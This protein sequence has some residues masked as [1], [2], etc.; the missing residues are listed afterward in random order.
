MSRPQPRTR[1]RNEPVAWNGQI[2]GY[3]SDVRND[4]FDLYGKWTPLVGSVT[5]DFLTRLRSGDQLWVEIGQAEPILSGTVEE[6]P[7]DTIDIRIRVEV[8]D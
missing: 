5:D 2:V 1:D 7:T 4:M 6:E 3:L 8:S